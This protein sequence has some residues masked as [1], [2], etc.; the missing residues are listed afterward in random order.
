M[1]L[2]RNICSANPAT[3][4]RSHAGIKGAAGVDTVTVDL[5]ESNVSELF[6]FQ[7]GI[8]CHRPKFSL[9]H[10]SLLYSPKFC[11]TPA[12]SSYQ[13]LRQNK[14]EEAV[15]GFFLKW[16]WVLCPSVEAPLGCLYTPTMSSLCL[17]QPKEKL[18]GP[19][20]KSLQSRSKLCPYMC[21]IRCKHVRKSK[22]KRK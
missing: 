19:A 8:W 5:Q 21:E 16:R 15:G 6:L 20:C 1:S 10:F 2:V 12:A 17:K 4:R 7:G 14:E 22:G 9:E 13:D 11:L 3:Q 18:E